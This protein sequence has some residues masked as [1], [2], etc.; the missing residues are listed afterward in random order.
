M[1]A[2]KHRAT[3]TVTP[4][5]TI[6]AMNITIS[7]VLDYIFTEIIAAFTLYITNNY[8]VKRIPII[9][10]LIIALIIVKPSAINEYKSK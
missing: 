2:Y 3:Q 1:I 9:L 8:S 4:A 10:A 7:N 5:A 6:L